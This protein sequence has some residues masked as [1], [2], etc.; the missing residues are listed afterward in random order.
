MYHIYSISQLLPQ[1]TFSINI[2]DDVSRQYK[3]PEGLNKRF[4]KYLW[5]GKTNQNIFQNTGIKVL[6]NSEIPKP[7]SQ[8]NLYSVLKDE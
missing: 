7:E 4:L 3:G 8:L 6:L 2:L 5:Q 1:Y